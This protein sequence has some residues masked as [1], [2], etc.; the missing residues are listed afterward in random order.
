MSFYFNNL[1]FPLFERKTFFRKRFP[2]FQVCGTAENISQTQI[3]YRLC[4]C[5]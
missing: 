5:I 4:N 2:Q 1:R 3:V